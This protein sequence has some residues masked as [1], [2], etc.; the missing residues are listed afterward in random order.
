[1]SISKSIK[2]ELFFIRRLLQEGYFKPHYWTSYFKN[3]FFGNYLFTKLPVLEYEAD[4]KIELHTICSRHSQGLWMF[5]WMVRSFVFHSGLRPVVI[6]HDDGTLDQATANLIITKFPNA[7]VWFRNETARLITEKPEVPDIVKKARANC[8]F[9]LDKLV[10]SLVLSRAQKL[11]MSDSDILYYNPPT[12]VA[13]FVSG[14]TNLDMLVQRQANEYIVHD[15]GMDNY[16]NDKYKLEEKKVALMNGGYLM[17]DRYKFNLGQ[18]AEFLEHVKRP[19]TDYFI[20]MSGWS[21]LMAQA[22]FEFLPPDRYAIKGFLNDKMVMKH[23]TSPRRYEMFAYGIDEA[24]KKISKILP[25][26]E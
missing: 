17:L 9:F 25:V 20:E 8:H 4:P 22:N 16:Y 11:I 5:A 6:V 7:K 12:E 24:R 19:F 1:M 3:R 13:D 21:S 18:V 2:T 15:V 23:Y 14:K 10:D 26:Q